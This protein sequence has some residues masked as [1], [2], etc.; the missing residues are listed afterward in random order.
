MNIQKVAQR[1]AA[2][3]QATA[4]SQRSKGVHVS[5]CW[6]TGAPEGLTAAAYSTKAARPLL[7]AYQSLRDEDHPFWPALQ[8]QLAADL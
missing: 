3:L 6:W 8:R 4:A 5:A 1:V 7:A 2:A